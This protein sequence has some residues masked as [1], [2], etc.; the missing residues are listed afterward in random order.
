LPF[1]SPIPSDIGRLLS[2]LTHEARQRLMIEQNRIMGEAAQRGSLRSN[3]I[4]VTVAKV[5]D[6]IHRA[7]MDR[8]KALMLQ[9]VERTQASPTEITEIARP[10]LETL[11]GNL[12]GVI[13]P[14]S[15]PADHKRIVDQ[16]TAAFQQRLEGILRDTEI[17]L[18]NDDEFAGVTESE[19]W[20]RA[21]EAVAMLKSIMTE[22]SARLRICE[23]AHAGLI[24][25]RAEQYHYGEHVLPDHNV[26]K[27][28]WWAEGH[29]ALEQDWA[30]GDF[31]TWIKRESVQLKA[32]GVTFA[33]A[34]IERLLPP[35]S[36]VKAEVTVHTEEDEQIIAKLDAHVPSAA[37]SYKQAILDLKDASR[38][39]FR[40]PALELREALR[41]VLDHL[42]PD[43]EVTAAPE[44]KQEKERDGPTMRQKV[45][46][47]MKR[48]GKR[49]SSD[50]PEQSVTAFEEAIAALRDNR[51][52]GIDEV[53]FWNLQTITLHC[54]IRMGWIY[55]AVVQTRRGNSAE[56]D[57]EYTI[58]ISNGRLG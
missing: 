8:A 46:F 17:G 42:A 7:S 37:L 30:A 52:A 57:A 24:R 10:Y 11:G 38:V 12:L 22:Y 31:S 6:E 9:F 47:I 29:Q 3:R 18:G 27:E 34:D 36:G 35:P 41:E 20:V 56:A 15:F 53:E 44:Y 49:S 21:A 32:F 14:N 40:G 48:R 5:A 2:D 26:P 43:S 55:L 4:I 19:A 16:H 39:S 50:V 58:P 23:R 1:Q 13:R 25:A 51:G 54:V 33:R 45:R 28:F